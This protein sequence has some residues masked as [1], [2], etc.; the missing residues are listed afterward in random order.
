VTAAEEE[1]TSTV[2]QLDPVMMS[3]H[4][5]RR[6]D[7]GSAVPG[8]DTS[9]GDALLASMEFRR[10]SIA[11]TRVAELSIGDV[12]IQQRIVEQFQ[13]IVGGYGGLTSSVTDNKG[14][15]LLARFG[16]PLHTHEDDPVRAASAIADFAAAMASMGTQCSA[17]VATGRALYGVVGNA[18]RKAITMAGDVINVAARLST[19]ARGTVLCDQE[20]AV[21]AQ[22]RYGFAVMNPIIVKGKADAVVVFE[23]LDDG[24]A[25]DS[26]VVVLAGDAGLGKSALVDVFIDSAIE[27]GR[28]PLVGRTDAMDR[29][30]PLLAWRG[31]LTDILASAAGP[32]GSSITEAV[33]RLLPSE[34][35]EHAALLGAALGDRAAADSL[36]ADDERS[37]SLLPQLA[38]QV[39]TAVGVQHIVVFEDAHWADIASLA[40]LDSLAD[41]PD[42]P[43]MLVSTRPE[44]V[45]RVSKV[46]PEAEL[47]ELGAVSDDAVREMVSDQL[48]G[49]DLPD[50]LFDFVRPRVSGHPFFCEQLMKGL[51]EAGMVLIEGVIVSRF[52]RLDPAAQ[53]CLKAAAVVGRRHTAAAV[54][55]CV[56]EAPGGG[57][58]QGGAGH[59]S[60]TVTVMTDLC[61]E[62]V[63]RPLDDGRFE[64][65]HVI[66]CDVIY[67][68]MTDAQSRQFH[69]TVASHLEEHLRA[70]GPSVIGRHWASAGRPGLAV[71]FLEVA[72]ADARAGGSFADTLAL[73]QEA[74]GL[75]EL[76][77]MPA[78]ARR[79]T[80]LAVQ[81]A[82]ASYYLGLLAEARRDLAEVVSLLDVALPETD[83]GHHAEHRRLE[84]ELEQLGSEPPEDQ[85]DASVQA[86]TVLLETYKFLVKVQYLLG[87]SG[88]PIVT[89]S[90]RGLACA[91][92][93]GRYI[94]GAAIQANVSGAY[95][96]VGDVERFDHHGRSAIAVVEGPH[97]AVVANR[98]WRMMAVAYAGLG[99]RASGLGRWE[100]SVD[101]SDRALAALDPE[102]QNRDSGIWQTRSAVHL[103]AGEPRLHGGGRATSRSATAIRCSSGGHASMRLRR[104]SNATRSW[105]PTWCS[106]R[107][108]PISVR[109]RICWGRS[110]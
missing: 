60:E 68:L 38:A 33:R 21:P 89:S 57:N 95:A 88:L 45:A 78:D 19:T 11:M 54:Q 24:G 53:L 84:E 62:G 39:L 44:G 35:Q 97:G 55:A 15:R 90:L 66:A 72:A 40:V 75:R 100:A 43:P 3:R 56:D 91:F 101:A 32:A 14:V 5:L 82:R 25:E 63:L 12:D 107:P 94:E 6:T 71:D 79:R 2:Q 13:T 51:L 29:S 18:D 61:D 26:R 9:S 22:A 99:P 20:T 74:Q 46:A 85:A 96:V 70:S 17:G 106:S 42:V 50:E 92:R 108:C 47:L 16:T 64:F 102:G 104:S 23:L 4:L 31:A 83:E 93:L 7:A 109:R 69:G 8:S 41:L 36:A 105:R 34:L 58:L 52:D 73:L 37:G 86:D 77:D 30:T 98:V 10:L 48:G 110:R 103:C 65:Q 67:D 80:E 1:V 28:H 27:Q 87:E 59:H 81:S 76:A 49:A